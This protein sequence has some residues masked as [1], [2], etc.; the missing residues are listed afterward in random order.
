MAYTKAKLLSILSEMPDSTEIVVP[1]TR[2]PA[3]AV[4]QIARHELGLNPAGELMLILTPVN[5]IPFRPTIPQEVSNES[6]N[7]PTSGSAA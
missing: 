7:D 1:S 3:T 2:N 5:I 4:T 6:P